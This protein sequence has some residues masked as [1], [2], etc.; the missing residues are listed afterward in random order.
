MDALRIPIIRVA[1]RARFNHPYLIASPGCE[2]MNLYMAVLTPHI[3]DEMGAGVMLR[4]FYLMASVA[5]DGLGL[6]SRTFC[7][8]FLDIRDIPVAAVTGIGAVDR[9]GELGLIDIFVALEALG[10][11]DA[12]QTILPA[13]DLELLL[14]ELNFLTHFQ[15]L[16]ERDGEEE[17][18]GEG[19]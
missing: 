8:V 3:V 18:N 9:F 11:V 13:A 4:S 12:F 17:E 15:L 7:G 5:G 6:D 14:G 16:S 19:K 10:V 2:L 1:E